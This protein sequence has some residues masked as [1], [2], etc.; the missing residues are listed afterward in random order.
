MIRTYNEGFLNNTVYGIQKKSVADKTPVSS[1]VCKSTVSEP[2]FTGLFSAWRLRTTLDN[3]DDRKQ[4]VNVLRSLDKEGR[5]MLEYLLKTGILMQKDSQNNTALYNLN[6][7]ITTERAQGLS[8][9]GLLK[10]TVE[11]MANPYNVSQILGDIPSSYAKHVS[12]TVLNDAKEK[13][14]KLNTDEHVAIL[15]PSNASNQQAIGT[16]NNIHSGTCPA[17]SMEFDLASENPAEFARFAEGLSSKN[18]AVTK[19]IQLNSISENT[20]DTVWLLN[21]FNI[22]YEAKDFKTAQLL[23]TPDKNAIIRAQIQTTH[24]NDDERSPLD[25]LMQSTFMN[26]GSQQTYDS[27]T[28]TRGGQF[29]SDDNG[30][31]EMEKTFVESV[32]NNRNT[33]SVIYQ[34][35]QVEEV[36]APNSPEADANGKIYKQKLAGH[37]K[38]PQVVKQQIVDTLKSGKNVIIGYTFTDDNNYIIGGHEVTISGI[39]INDKGQEEFIYNDTDSDSYDQKLRNNKP[40]YVLVDE[41]LPKIHHAGIPTEIAEKD[42]AKPVENWVNAVND[43]QTMVKKA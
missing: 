7:I 8:A 6:K 27:I 19:E 43:F 10:N 22:P 36:N 39:R 9:K 4:Y 37:T 28:D 13:E 26:V 11:T 33:T 18:M 40:K 21:A 15:V 16:L 3:K 34:D 32:V 41:F 29:D 35:I 31:I 17:A 25:V 12:N 20:L 24:Q 23:F 38:S 5:N 14:S 42:E 2:S 30:L 1:P